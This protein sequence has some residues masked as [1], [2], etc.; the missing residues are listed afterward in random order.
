MHRVSSGN[1]GIQVSWYHP[2]IELCPISNRNVTGF[3]VCAGPQPSPYDRKIMLRFP[4][5]SSGTLA[6]QD[7]TWYHLVA[8]YNGTV[9]KVYIDGIEQISYSSTTPPVVYSDTVLMVGGGYFGAPNIIIDELRIDKVAITADEA[10]A[11]YISN[12]P[13]FPRDPIFIA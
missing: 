1:L 3:S 8:T 7:N 5:G 6:I 4:G 9:Y 10:Y 2:I 13:F 12:A 11:W